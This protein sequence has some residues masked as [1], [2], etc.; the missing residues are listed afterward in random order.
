MTKTEFLEAL[1][2]ALNGNMAAA[3]VEDNLKFYENYFYSE[4]AKGRSEA[5]LLSELGDPRILAR[6]LIDAAERAGDAYAREANETQ[7]RAASGAQNRDEYREE[8]Y[9]Q[10]NGR[11]VQRVHMPGWLI[12]ILVI[13]V[14]VVVISVVGSLMWAILPYLIPVVLVVYIIRLFQ[15][16]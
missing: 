11:T 6:T 12:A 5:A 2:R 8:A 4:E 3:S 7:F 13:M 10:G 1:R 15:K 14:F 9:S 16:K